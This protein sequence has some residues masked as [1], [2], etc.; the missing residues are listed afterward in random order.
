MS[1]TSIVEVGTPPKRM[2]SLSDTKPVYFSRTS[3]ERDEYCKR[4]RY[5]LECFGERGIV[6]IQSG[7]DLVFGNIIHAAVEQ[8]AKVGYIDFDG[9]R[10]STLAEAGKVFN[11][12][13]SQAWASL[14]EGLLRGFCLTVWPRLMEEYEVYHTEQDCA[15]EIEPNVWFMFRQDLVLK[16]KFN[17][18]LVYYELKT[19][20]SAANDWIASW[21]KSIQLH[22]SM[23]AI[24]QHLGVDIEYAIIQGLYKGYADRKSGMR[25]SPMTQ[26]YVDRQYAMTPRYSFKYERGREWEK[27]STFNEWPTLTNWVNQMPKD[28]LSEQYPQTTPIA[29]RPLI[30]QVF[31]RQQLIREREIMEARLELQSCTDM[32]RITYLLDRHFKQNFNKCQQAYGNSPC[33][34][35]HI[36]WQPWVEADPLGSALYKPRTPHHQSERDYYG[37]SET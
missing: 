5:Y 7:W 34:Y 27:F 17:G 35:I 4:A 10:T 25:V 29:P 31:F 15:W 19:T 26:G 24:K 9:V 22:S 30:A 28:Q 6:P 1:V 20:S 16:N 18:Q 2:T 3:A 12:L 8:L 37:I 11:T 13:P 33:D 21:A 23:Y 32:D 14:A 36:C